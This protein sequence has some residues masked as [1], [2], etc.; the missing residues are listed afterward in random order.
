M[1]ERSVCS[2]AWR[3][4]VGSWSLLFN[5]GTST[6]SDGVTRSL[7]PGVCSGCQFYQ[8]CYLLLLRSGLQP[9]EPQSHQMG[10]TGM[11]NH[12]P[13][14]N[15]A[16]KWILHCEVFICYYVNNNNNSVLET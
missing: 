4:V 16:F 14:T 13:K 7:C 10:H 15:R 5:V 12:L 8:F 2:D 11:F 1:T 6:S 3:L 9:T